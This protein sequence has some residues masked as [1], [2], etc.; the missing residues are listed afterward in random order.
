[1]DHKSV[2]FITEVWK[3][4]III[5]TLLF[6]LREIRKLKGGGGRVGELGSGQEEGAESSAH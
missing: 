6:V 4:P 2:N 5:L 1:M 3:N